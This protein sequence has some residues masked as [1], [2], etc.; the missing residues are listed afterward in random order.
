MI[1]DARLLV[2]DALRYVH[3][4]PRRA[5]VDLLRPGD[6]VVAND[7]ATLPASLYGV[8]AATGAHVEA[9]LAG[10]R[11]L[12]D[13]DVSN[14]LALIFGDGDFHTRTENRA[15]PPPLMPGDRLRLGPL[16]AS[17]TG[18][19]DHPRFVSLHFDGSPASIWAGIARHGRPIQY[20]HVQT[21]LALWDV[22]TPIAGRPAAFEPPS[23]GF[24]LD[25]RTVT[26]LHDQGIGFTTITHA[27]GI[28]STGDERLDSR[29]PLDEPYE[30][31]ETAA[32]AI[33]GTKHAGGRIVAVGTTVVRALEH[34]ASGTGALHSGHGLA[35][36]RIGPSTRLRIVDA[37]LTGVHERG[38]S[39]YELLRAF[40]DAVTLEDADEWLERYHYRTHEFGDSVF[41]EHSRSANDASAGQDP[42]LHFINREF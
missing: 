19:L 9:R 32:A 38:T 12:N 40:V 13:L 35:T 41:V 26:A 25:W 30:I 8:H 1:P 21:P 16:T 2:V 28:S 31:S 10:I 39:H 18:I 33:N 11:T 7:A 5:F 20:A 6:L 37:I 22:W 23:A 4:L 29:L 34:A 36:Q 14:F 27:A 3:D 24:A 42:R 15:P 17:I